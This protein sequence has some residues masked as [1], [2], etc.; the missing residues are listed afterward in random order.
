MI[1]LHYLSCT[2]TFMLLLVI[3]W[4][5][6]NLTLKYIFRNIKNKVH[7]TDVLSFMLAIFLIIT[8]VTISSPYK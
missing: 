8:C 6:I 1:I 2:I 7:V 3:I 5:L 4:S